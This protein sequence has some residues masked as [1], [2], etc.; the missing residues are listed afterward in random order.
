MPNF[1]LAILKSAVALSWPTTNRTMRVLVLCLIRLYSSLCTSFPFDCRLFFQLLFLLYPHC[2]FYFVCRHFLY[3][4][5]VT[6]IF[7]ASIFFL[8]VLTLIFSLTPFLY[9]SYEN[10]TNLVIKIITNLVG[11]ITDFVNRDPRRYHL[12]RT[13]RHRSLWPIWWPY[14][15]AN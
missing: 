2:P 9:P 3:F 13:I 12:H 10:F 4:R 5:N 14:W 15:N 11:E 1:I 6:Y 7:S 8:F